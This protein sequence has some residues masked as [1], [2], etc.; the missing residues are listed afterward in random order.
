MSNKSD[1]I[2]L[3]E[4][5]R[6]RFEALE[7]IC[8][9]GLQNDAADVQKDAVNKFLIQAALLYTDIKKRASLEEL[10]VEEREFLGQ[11]EFPSSTMIFICGVITKFLR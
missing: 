11:K 5:E 9:G 2:Y 1:Y 10:T 4:T 7:E 6:Q 8:K 3:T